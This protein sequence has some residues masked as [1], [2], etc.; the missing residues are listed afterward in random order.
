MGFPGNARGKPRFAARGRDRG[1]P[2]LPHRRAFTESCPLITVLASMT[3]GAGVIVDRWSWDDGEFV[4]AVRFQRPAKRNALDA[5]LLSQ[6]AQAL[7]LLA[8]DPR[9]RL[10]LLY[11]SEGFF[12]AG[13][14]LDTMAAIGLSGEAAATDLAAQ[15]IAVLRRLDSFPAPTIAAVAGGAYGFG[16]GLA[17]ATRSTVLVPKTRLRLSE[18]RLGVVGALLLPWLEPRIRPD[19]LDRWILSGAEF[20][21]EE[22][23][24]AGLGRLAPDAASLYETVTSEAMALL[25][26]AP[27]V[28]RAYLRNRRRP[29]SD[30]DRARQL[31]QSLAS[32]IYRDAVAQLRA[33]QKTPWQKA[34]P[35]GW[36]SLRPH[37]NGKADAP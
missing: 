31:G 28:Q 9:C 12:C 7:D 27:A 19:A 5:V 37:L 22:A 4:A 8:Q 20:P 1:A 21:S 15:L 3:K 11:G 16:V 35:P 32:S 10:L 2:V 25:A 36:D 18:A 6:L 26:G 23:A 24:Q 33:G 29:V 30:E 17:A 13:A 14:D 34:V